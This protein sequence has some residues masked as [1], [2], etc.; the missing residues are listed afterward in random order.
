MQDQGWIVDSG[1]TYHITNDA[2]NFKPIRDC[3]KYGKNHLFVGNGYDV[4]VY[5]I[6]YVVILCTN[7]NTSI[8]LNNVLFNPQITRKLVS[9]SK[10]ATDNNV[11]VEIDDKQCLVKDRMTG[12]QVLKATRREGL[13]EIKG[14]E[15]KCF[16]V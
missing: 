1:A 9:V 6:G 14:V 8:N 10:L 15:S 11:C 7:N 16:N 2:T 13:N 4:S 3:G 12:T 5:K